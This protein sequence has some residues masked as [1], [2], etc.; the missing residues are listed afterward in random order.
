MT[1]VEKALSSCFPGGNLFSSQFM[2]IHSQLL[3]LIIEDASS[4]RSYVTFFTTIVLFY[5]KY[6]MKVIRGNLSHGKAQNSNIPNI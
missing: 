6:F 4:R 5:G 1:P 2:Y 3:C